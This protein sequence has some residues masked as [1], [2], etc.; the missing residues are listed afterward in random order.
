MRQHGEVALTSGLTGNKPL[1]GPRLDSFAQRL[2]ISPEDNVLV[3]AGTICKYLGVASINTLWRWVE[4]YAFPAI[5]RPDGVWMSTMTAI[6]QWIFLAAEV[7]NDNLE[8]TRGLNTTAKIA[9]ERLERQLQNPDEFAAKRAA[10][11][12]RAARGVGLLPGRKEPRVPYLSSGMER[13]LRAIMNNERDAALKP[14]TPDAVGQCQHDEDVTPLNGDYGRG[15]VIAHRCNN[16]GIVWTYDD[17][18][19]PSVLP[20][21]HPTPEV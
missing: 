2:Y 18:G 1:G 17:Q 14:A 6:D 5:K 20:S 15:P 7:V 21:F 4:L 19:S 12:R 9:H 11:A 8:H 13:A 16:C 3:G 10:T